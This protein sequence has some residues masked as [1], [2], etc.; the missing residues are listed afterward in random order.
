V[1][2]LARCATEDLHNTDTSDTNNTQSRSL[3]SLSL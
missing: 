2:H 3:P 1:V